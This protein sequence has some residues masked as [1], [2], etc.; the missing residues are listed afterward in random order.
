MKA[1]LQNPKFYIWTVLVL[2]PAQAVMFVYT[3]QTNSGAWAA[4]LMKQP[5]RFAAINGAADKLMWISL[6]LFV[7]DIACLLIAVSRME[8]KGTRKSKEAHHNLQP[9]PAIN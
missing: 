3:L 2:L 1:L 5:E 6:A 9:L 7:I 4:L 8:H